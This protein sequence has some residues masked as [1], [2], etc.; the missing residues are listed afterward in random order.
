MS[1]GAIRVYVPPLTMNRPPAWASPAGLVDAHS[2]IDVVNP[3]CVAVEMYVLPACRIG[4]VF[5]LKYGE[6]GVVVGLQVYPFR[7]R[8]CAVM[9]VFRYA[10]FKVTGFV[11]VTLQNPGTAFGV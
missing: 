11:V 1:A 2:S 5:V 4:G 3:R 8:C 7:Y 6:A 10:L 9:M